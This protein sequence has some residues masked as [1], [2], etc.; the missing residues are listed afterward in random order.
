M[1]KMVHPARFERATSAFGEPKTNILLYIYND[2]AAINV[3]ETDLKRAHM[4][5]KRCEW[6]HFGH[7]YIF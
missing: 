6:A 1:I 5:L 2:L 3:P 7:N 4:S